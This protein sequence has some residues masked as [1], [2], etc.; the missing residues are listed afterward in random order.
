MTVA[1]VIGSYRDAVGVEHVVSVATEP[2]GLSRVRDHDGA[3]WEDIGRFRDPEEAVQSARTYLRVMTEIFAEWSKDQEQGGRFRGA[4]MT[5]AYG[6]GASGADGSSGPGGSP[7]PV[8]SGGRGD[9]A[10]HDTEGGE[11]SSRTTPRGRAGY[12]DRLASPGANGDWLEP[13]EHEQVSPLRVIGGVLFLVGY[14]L[15]VVAF[16]VWFGQALGLIQ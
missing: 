11:S 6:E 8:A 2:Y 9:N 7:S 1:S 12:Q 14:L 13:W 5:L 10:A 3:Q 4:R 16:F 15:A